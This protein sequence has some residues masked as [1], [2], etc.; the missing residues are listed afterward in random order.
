MLKVLATTAKIFSG[1]NAYIYKLLN[2]YIYI[3]VHAER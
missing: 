1:T 3:W 2:I